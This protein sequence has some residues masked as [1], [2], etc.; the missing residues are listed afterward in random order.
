MAK[1]VFMSIVVGYTRGICEPLVSAM[2][3]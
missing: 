3:D 2:H 1:R